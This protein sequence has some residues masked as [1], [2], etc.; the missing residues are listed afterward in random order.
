MYI[1]GFL[2]FRNRLVKEDEFVMKH[3]KITFSET[4]YFYWNSVV[5]YQYFTVVLACCLQFMDLRPRNHTNSSFPDVNAAAA[6]IAFILATIYPWI[7]FFYMRSRKAELIDV[8]EVES[9]LIFVFKNRYAE[10]FFRFMKI[11]I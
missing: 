9:N 3:F 7:H 4:P 5:Y 6:V 8:E 11:D 10:I 1:I 2:V